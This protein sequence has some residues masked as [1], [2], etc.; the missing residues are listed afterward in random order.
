MNRSFRS[1]PIAMVAVCLLLMSCG[2][3]GGGD[4]P[5]GGTTGGGTTGG[6]TGGGST[7]G[8][9]GGSA[10][11]SSPFSYDVGVGG[12]GGIVGPVTRFGSIVINGLVLSTDDADFYIEDESGGSQS[13]R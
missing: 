9:G 13:D 11:P 12:T 5:S 2:G 7:G 4:A 1:R 8:S 6:S 3:G 10:P